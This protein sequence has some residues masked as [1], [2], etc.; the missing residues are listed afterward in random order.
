MK[1]ARLPDIWLFCLTVGLLVIGVFLVFDASYARAGQSSFTGGDSFFYMK[2]QAMYAVVG[3]LAMFLA[4]Y[5]PYW[6]LRKW[7]I[8]LL[9]VSVVLLTAVIV[10]GA[11]IN[12]AKRWIMLPGGIS[13][14]PSEFAK[15]AIVI[16]LAGLLA[17]KR[18]DIRDLRRGFVHA[19]LPLPVIGGLIMLQPDMGTTIVIAVTVFLMV[20]VAGARKRHLIAAGAAAILVGIVLVVSSPYRFERVS[21]FIN[22]FDDYHGSGYQVCQSLMALGTGGIFGVGLCEGREKL[23]YLPAEHTDFI[24]A[25]LGEELGLIGTLAMVSLF[26]WFGFRGLTIA[27]KTSSLFGRFLAAG[28]TGLICG[29]ALLNMLVITSS[30]PATGVPLPFISY[31]GSSLVINL[32]CV[33]ILLGVSRL[34]GPIESYLYENH[35]NRR[36]YRRTRLP[37]DR[38]RSSPA[39]HP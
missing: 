31:G 20:F 1:S 28:I 4:M 26:L 35:S 24:L 10:V 30:V 9:V 14:Q 25:T 15:L 6:R 13:V 12:G 5:T 29:Q 18:H 33:G 11:E 17:V 37:G 23:F 22:P 8:G 3:L 36:R 2:K 27:Y 16:Y 34:P 32:F 38:R 21:S 7:G 19:L 39:E